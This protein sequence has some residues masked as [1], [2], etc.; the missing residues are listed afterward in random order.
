MKDRDKLFQTRSEWIDYLIGSR[1]SGDKEAFAKEVGYELST[2]NH[3]INPHSPRRCGDRA[4]RAIESA[5]GLSRH[6]L[7]ESRKD[8]KES[9]YVAISTNAQYTYETVS[10]LKNEQCVQECAAVLGDFDIL[11]KVEVDNFHFLDILLAKLVKFPGVKRSQTF[12]AIDSLHWQRQQEQRMD[13]PPKEDR[14]YI[15]NG[16]DSFIYK[17]MS[18][19]FDQVKLLEKDPIV[20]KDDEPASIHSFELLSGT[21][22]SMCAIRSYDSKMRGFE[23]FNAKEKSLIENG[24]KS[25]RIIILDSKELWKKENW[26]IVRNQ[27]D[28][29]KSIGCSVRFLLE[30]KWYSSSHKIGLE[31]FLILDESFVCIRDETPTSYDDEHGQISI[32]RNPEMVK[33]YQDTFEVNWKNSYDF[34]ELYNRYF[35][36]KK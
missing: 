15:H 6:T 19:L 1:F 32:F 34:D 36:G 24:V 3:F 35:T 27:Y 4:A 28:S 11:I 8:K 20:I 18:Y 22:R 23:D 10:Q 2:I 21:K 7:D 30:S 16:V 5:L 13:I 9:Y 31:K 33:N 29:Y 25:R 14:L 26:S 12:K 17:K